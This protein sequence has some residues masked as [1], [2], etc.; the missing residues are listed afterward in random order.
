MRSARKA[1]T[2]IELLVVVAII[3][4]LI[5]IL[6]PGLMLAQEASNEL[7]CKTQMDQIFNMVKENIRQE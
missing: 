5:A 4:L 3:G 2:L 6:I 1:F 7:R